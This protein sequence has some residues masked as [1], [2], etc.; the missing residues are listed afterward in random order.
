MISYKRYLE[1]MYTLI[2]WRLSIYPLV[3]R[4]FWVPFSWNPRYLQCRP[5]SK[6][7]S[8]RSCLCWGRCRA[9]CR[10]SWSCPPPPSPRCCRR[11]FRPQPRRWS[12]WSRW[13]SLRPPLRWQFLLGF[14]LLQILLELKKFYLKQRRQKVLKKE[15]SV[16][17]SHQEK[18]YTICN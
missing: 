5:A 11:R 8:L 10:W 7:S 9:R 6:C 1:C 2:Q 14:L 13:R 18:K 17:I 15:L 4:E 12:R 3:H 16:L